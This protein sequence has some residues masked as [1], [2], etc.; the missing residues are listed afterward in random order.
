M[1]RLF[2]AGFAATTLLFTP[3]IP[4]LAQEAAPISQ[5]EPIAET[6]YGKVQG[7]VKDGVNV[8]LGIPYG[9]DTS[10]TRFEPPQ[11]PEPWGGILEANSYPDTTPQLAGNTA[12]F[13]SWQPDPVPEM[14]EN[15][16]GLNIW[17]PGLDDRRRPVMV[18]LHGGGFQ[19]GSGSSTAYEGVNLANRGDVVVVSINHRLN[20]LGYLYLAG[21]TDD[22]AYADSGNVG[23]LDMVQAL[24]WVRDNIGTFGGNPE[25]VTIFGESGGGRKVSVLNAM[26]MAEG[27]FDRAIVQS[28][29]MLSFRTPEQAHRDTL[30]FL[31]AVGLEGGDLEGLKVLTQDEIIAGLRKAAAMSSRSFSWGPV[32]DGR[33][34]KYDPFTAPA[35]QPNADVPMLIGSNKDELSLWLMRPGSSEPTLSFQAVKGLIGE[36]VTEDE[37]EDIVEAYRGEFPDYS[38]GQILVAMASDVRYSAN[39]VRQAKKKAEQG[40]APV[41]L[42][43]FDWETP[44]VGGIYKTPHALEI[45]FAFD[46]LGNSESMVGSDL[47]VPQKVADQ[48]S[49]AWISFARH[50]DPNARGLPFW[51][52]VTEDDLQA[53]RFNT[54]SE[55]DEDYF[56]AEGGVLFKNE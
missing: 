38:D 26:G 4:A 49:E 35:P 55:V 40:T 56:D 42:Y 12:V 28:G 32:V 5:A 21:M 54:V 8:F 20:A 9:A 45:P 46:T 10:V 18:W 51:P 39:A 13:A 25:N 48:V 29:S 15:M 30:D 19:S 22:P 1:K 2:L 43:Q 44:V 14:S 27:L 16:L 53:M 50:G 31:K 17:T 52:S 34:L 24:E 36:F 41:W 37:F 3:Q 47:E 6:Q 11:P 33:S 23:T 7:H